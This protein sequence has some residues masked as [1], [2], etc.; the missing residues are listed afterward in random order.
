LLPN[1]GRSASESPVGAEK[2]RAD[3]MPRSADSNSAGRGE[4]ALALPMREYDNVALA[5]F[6]VYHAINN[7][8]T[9]IVD[10]G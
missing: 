3:G 8:V 7:D 6:G 9:T 4:V 2:S 10:A 5:L 1:D